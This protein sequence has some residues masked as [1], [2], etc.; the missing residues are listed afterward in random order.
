LRNGRPFI[1]D[2][3]E[4]VEVF[5][6]PLVGLRSKTAAD[7]IS[8]SVMALLSRVW[9]L[10]GISKVNTLGTNVFIY[11]GAGAVT[12][13]GT[14]NGVQIVAGVLVPEA[15]TVPEGLEIIQTPAGYAAHLTYFGDYARLGSAHEVVLAWCRANQRKTTGTNWEVYGHHEEDPRKRRTEVYYQLG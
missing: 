15:T 10:I 14:E 11:Q 3:V 8:T 2:I 13:S 5:A 12:H 6:Q 9:K 4:V 1:A 7:N